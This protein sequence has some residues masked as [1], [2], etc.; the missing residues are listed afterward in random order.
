MRSFGISTTA[1]LLAGLGW[2]AVGDKPYP[3]FTP[4]NFVNT[5][6]L[7]GRNFAA[8]NAAVAKQD[9]ENAKAHLVRSRELLAVTV[10]FWRDGKK[11]DAIQILRDTLTKMDALD[12]ALSAEKIDPAAASAAAQQIGAGCQRCH[13]AYREQDPATKAYRFKKAALP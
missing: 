13:A 4:D 11:D 12:D 7:V 8:I 5:M 9:F 6:Q 2:A 10:T 1:L 3:I